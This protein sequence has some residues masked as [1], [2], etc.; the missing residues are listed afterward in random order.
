M[1]NPS[2]PPKN[3]PTK[4]SSLS[5]KNSLPQK[6]LTPPKKLLPSQRSTT[7]IP[8]P[9]P[10]DHPNSPYHSPT[11]PKP[12][13]NSPTLLHPSHLNLNLHLHRH[14][15]PLLQRPSYS[16]YHS[17]TLPKNLTNSPTLLH[18]SHLH[19]PPS[20]R[21]PFTS[22][23]LPHP[24]LPSPKTI[25]LPPITVPL[26]LKP[27]LIPQHY[28]TLHLVTSSPLHFSSPPNDPLPKSPSPFPK[29]H[30]NSPL[31]QSHTP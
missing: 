13:T 6:K 3:L 20:P 25:L 30:P 9:F 31:S 12:L 17:P 15:S 8:S 29:D 28:F 14:P 2:S 10:K 18:P 1:P 11:L 21:H 4:K 27:S 16:P 22:S 5:H 7:Q 23:R 24:P 26:S 19:L